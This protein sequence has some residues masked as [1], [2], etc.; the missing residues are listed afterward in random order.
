M[1]NV[2]DIAHSD[3][4]FLQIIV[5]ISYN[6]KAYLIIWEWSYYPQIWV[7]WMSDIFTIFSQYL[8]FRSILSFLQHAKVHPF[9]YPRYTYGINN[10]QMCN[11]IS[12]YLWLL[13][14]I[15]FDWYKR[16]L[17]INNSKVAIYFWFPMLWALMGYYFASDC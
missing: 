12:A 15:G 6:I 14:R 11:N 4:F 2:N 7:L 9:I 13:S 3:S 10:A 17:S 16:C 8:L 1:R 5:D